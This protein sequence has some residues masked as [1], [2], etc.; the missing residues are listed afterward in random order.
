MA[1]TKVNNL[2]MQSMSTNLTLEYTV[3][4]TIQGLKPIF[5]PKLLIGRKKNGN[6]QEERD[7]SVALF[8]RDRLEF[9]LH[10]LPTIVF[11]FCT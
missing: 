9:S 7:F 3:V 10:L 11:F 4:L 6:I 1:L 5:L 8:V 2:A